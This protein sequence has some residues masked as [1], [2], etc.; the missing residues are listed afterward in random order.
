MASILAPGWRSSVP[1]PEE[2]EPERYVLA[3]G[4]RRLVSHGFLLI[5]ILAVISYQGIVS[6][7][8]QTAPSLAW[9]GASAYSRYSDDYEK[10]HGV[11][12]VAPEPVTPVTV[13]TGQQE[14][15]SAAQ[16]VLAPV[17]VAAD[18]QPIQDSA[19]APEQRGAIDYEVVS[20]DVVSAIAERFGVT[21]ED[22]AWS[23]NLSSP[24]A[25]KLGQKLLIPPVFGLI[26]TVAKG[27]TLLSVTQK[28]EV[29]TEAIVGYGPN[30]LSNSKELSAGQVLVIP[31]GKIPPARAASAPSSRGGARPSDAAPALAAV[32]AA[33]APPSGHLVWPNQGLI[34]QR[35]SSYHDGLDIAS[36]YGSAIVAA[37]GGAV[38]AAGWDNLG[39]GN[40]ITIDHGNGYST[41]Y[42]HMSSFVVGAGDHVSQGQ[43]I[44]RIGS[45][46][47]STG[48]HVH[49]TVLR[50]GTP[51][52]PLSVL[53]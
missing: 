51:I 43:L 45:T 25:L 21:T 14:D 6:R 20:G 31:G 7:M 35:F 10:H 46:G 53:P 36:P 2:H 8:P 22:I 34:M 44:G 37:D 40:Y 50:N 52:N 9:N 39:L 38:A 11:P 3:V 49:F 29:S 23:N 32:S 19:A 27:D 12:L 5:L 33:G 16:S 26:H 42:G 17:S 4:Q 47:N 30:N 41:T 18:R 24:D 13:D 15:A 28:Y 1:A 48:P